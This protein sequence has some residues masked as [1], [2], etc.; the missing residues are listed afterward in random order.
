MFFLHF[1]FFV[2]YTV[3]LRF[4]EHLLK[5]LFFFFSFLGCCLSFSI[6]FL[7]FFFFFLLV[8]CSELNVRKVWNVCLLFRCYYIEYVGSLLTVLFC[9]TL[10]LHGL[11]GVNKCIANKK[12]KVDL[13]TVFL[14]NNIYFC[15]F[16][17]R[18]LNEFVDKIEI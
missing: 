14:I 12:G 6:V 10:I 2:M 17:S 13:Y 16:F 4:V 11:V 15:F 9:A 18:W 5:K 7:F 8:L 1:F 3:I